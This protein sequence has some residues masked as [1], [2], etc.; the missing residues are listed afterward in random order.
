[1]ASEA[2]TKYELRGAA[3]WITLDSPVN[4]NALSA[5][6]VG[7]LAAHLDAALR[8]D[9]A[10]CIVLSGAGSAFCAGA[11]LVERGAG[12]GRTA[13]GESPFVGILKAN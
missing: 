4:R 10:R 7:E 9:G 1:M 2:V 13:G 3:A 6:L 8:D 11:D 5:A 12:L